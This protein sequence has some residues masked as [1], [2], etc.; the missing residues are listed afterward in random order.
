MARKNSGVT[1]TAVAAAVEAFLLSTQ[2]TTTG[3]TVF[4]SGGAIWS[5]GIAT[6]QTSLRHSCSPQRSL[7]QTTWTSDVHRLATLSSVLA[8]DHTCLTVSTP[9]IARSFRH[10]TPF[11]FHV[12]LLHTT[13]SLSPDLRA[14]FACTI[15]QLKT[16]VSSCACSEQ[17]R[18]AQ[19]CGFTNTFHFALPSSKFT[20]H[21]W[22]PRHSRLEIEGC[23]YCTKDVTS[24][25][26][27]FFRERATQNNFAGD[28]QQE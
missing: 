11:L 12:L 15:Q 9:R 8:N 1:G 21:T 10:A 6:Q 13:H 23:S 22:H 5:A 20:L 26:F 16:Y 24:G 3:R 4:G 17:R 28:Y 2:E 14:V 19:H 27:A 18:L 7:E 25:T